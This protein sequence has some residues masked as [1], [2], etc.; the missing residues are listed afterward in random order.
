MGQDLER[1][2]INRIQLAAELSQ[3]RYGRPLV[4]AYSGGKDSDLC[5]ALTKRSSVDFEV[6]HNHTT[7]DAPET[8]YHVRDVFSQ[9]ENEGIT[10]RTNFPT[11]KGHRTTMWGLIAEKGMP[12]TRLQRYCCGVLK[13]HG[14]QNTFSM[15][16]VRWHESIKRKKNRGIYET[17]TRNAKDKIVLT[18]DSEENRAILESCRPSQK[19]ICN[20][21]VDWE[22]SD[23]WNYIHAEHIPMNPLYERGFN[24]VGCIGCPMAGRKRWTEFR[25]YPTYERAYHR[26]FEKMLEI[27]LTKRPGV[28]TNWKTADDVFRWWMEDKNVEGQISFEEYLSKNKQKTE[29]LF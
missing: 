14:G 3:S 9:L 16:G 10:C 27:R 24:R 1:Q 19:L 8:V 6:E 21:I 4:L 2:S 12:P 29:D 5:L 17:F 13:A 25:L 7:A 15:T 26:A 23:V 18:E 11:Y 20:P 22:N 28:P